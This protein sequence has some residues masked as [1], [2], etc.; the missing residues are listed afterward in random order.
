MRVDAGG[1]G[2]EQRPV[3]ALPEGYVGRCLYNYVEIEEKKYIYHHNVDAINL[4]SDTRKHEEITQKRKKKAF[5]HFSFSA[6]IGLGRCGQFLIRTLDLPRIP[7][8]TLYSYRLENNG[9]WEILEHPV[10]Y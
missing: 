10:R 1:L 4:N 8:G 3:A 5:G 7:S 9:P 6:M 2:C